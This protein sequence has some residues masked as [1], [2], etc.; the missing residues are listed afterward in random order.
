MAKIYLVRR[1]RGYVKCVALPVTWRDIQLHGLGFNADRPGIYLFRGAWYG[2]DL[3]RHSTFGK[4]EGR[5]D[6]EKNPR[7]IGRVSSNTHPL[8]FKHLL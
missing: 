7:L 5:L 1:W 4:I 6:R 8:R 3:T 2:R